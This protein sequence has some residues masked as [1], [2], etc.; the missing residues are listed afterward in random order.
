M[1]QLIGRE[2][3]LVIGGKFL[4]KLGRE[5]RRVVNNVEN[6]AKRVVGQ[7]GQGARDIRAGYRGE[8]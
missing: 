7:V 6:G 5:T 4:Y 2:I 8:L 3:E 1:R